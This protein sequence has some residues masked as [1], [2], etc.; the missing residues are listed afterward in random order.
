MQRLKEEELKEK[1]NKKQKERDLYEYQKLQYEQK[2]R[3]GLDDFAKL[4]ENAYKNMQRMDKEN[5]D[6]IKYAEG[7]IKEYKQ[8]GKNIYP[9]LIELKKYKQKYSMQ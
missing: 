7:H 8:Q 6:F 4:N 1:E 5:D 9:L 3:Q 2:R